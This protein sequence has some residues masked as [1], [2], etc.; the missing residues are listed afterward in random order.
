MSNH[1]L[2]R[3]GGVAA[4]LGLA[5]DVRTHLAKRLPSLGCTVGPATAIT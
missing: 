1:N 3:V 4:I 5:P 2:Y